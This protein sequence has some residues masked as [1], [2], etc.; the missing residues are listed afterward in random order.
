MVQKEI[1]EREAARPKDEQNV[2][3]F[4]LE[5][6]F[7]ELKKRFKENYENDPGKL[8][9]KISRIFFPVFFFVFNVIYWTYYLPKYS[10]RE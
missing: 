3:G 9:E 7:S 10:S 1:S 8:I 4:S 6:S 2:S 5:T